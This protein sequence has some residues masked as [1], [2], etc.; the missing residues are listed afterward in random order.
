[1]AYVLGSSG[2]ARLVFAIDTPNSHLEALTAT[3]QGRAEEEISMGIRW[4]Y[5]AGF[6]IALACMSVISM[7]HVHKEIE[8]LR[9]KKRWRLCG[10]FIVAIILLLLPLAE[11][12]DSLELV[13][14]V[15]GLI[16]FALILELWASS[17]RNEC[18]YTRSKPCKYVGHCGKK[19]LEALVRGGKEVDVQQLS[20]DPTKNSGLMVCIS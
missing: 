15:T 8:G 7:S 11:G 12:L 14:T 10:R 17:C 2:L 3:Y 19:D 5:C 13:G 4:F 1:M 6:A 20:R 16:V 18:L 9:L